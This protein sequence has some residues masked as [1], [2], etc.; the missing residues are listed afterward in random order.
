[1]AA[2]QKQLEYLQR[3]K[4]KGRELAETGHVAYCPYTNS[5]LVASG[6]TDEIYHVDDSF[7][8]CM[9]FKKVGKSLDCKH[10]EAIKYAIANNLVIVLSESFY[11]LS[12]L[13]I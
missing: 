3:R 4:D 5:W 6:T 2:S 13:V 7:C 8:P 10:R 1:M 11:Q 9:D 12:E